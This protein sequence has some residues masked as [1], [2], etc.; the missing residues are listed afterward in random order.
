MTP[1]RYSISQLCVDLGVDRRTLSKRLELAGI[2][3]VEVKG[4]TK[5]Y[6]MK[7]AVDVSNGEADKSKPGESE[8]AARA[9]L[10][11]ARADIHE[12]TAAE[13]AGDLVPTGSNR[14]SV[15]VDS[16]EY[17]RPH[18][19]PARSRCPRRRRRGRHQRN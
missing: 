8:S 16:R 4:R 5:L 3:P 15:V 12:A 18:N 13:I 6:R 19:R 10:T 11:R 7:D 1:G 9:R 2:E 17:S 14:K